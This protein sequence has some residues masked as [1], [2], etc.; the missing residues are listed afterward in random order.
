MK[1]LKVNKLRGPNIWANYPV[2]EAWVDLEEMKDTSS[3]MIPGFN[4]RL[5][6]WLPTMV[7][8]RCSIGE[9]GGFF[10]R[11]RRG[12]YMAHIL[13]HVTLE[14]QSL[15]G[16]P[17][18]FGRARETNTDG[19]YKVAIAYKEEKLALACLDKAFELIQ[20]AIHDTPLDVNAVVSEL[21]EYAYDVCLGPSTRSI[22]DAAKA[23]NIPWRRLNEGSLVQLGYGVHQRRICTAETDST[24]A[25]AESIAQDKELTRTLLRSIGIPTPEGR[26]VESAEDAWE[27]AEDIGLPVVVKPQYG[28]H[29]RGVATN[30]QTR[31]QVVAAYEAARQEGRSIIVERHAPGDDYRMLVVGGKLVAAARREPAHVIGDGQSTVQKLIDKVNEDP[32]RSDGHSTSLSLIKIDPVALG[33]LMD[34]GM[35]PDTIPPVGKKVLIRRNANLSTGGTAA[36]VTDQV[37]PDVA[38]HAVEAA[39]IIGLDIAGVDMVVQDISQPLQGQRGVIV[40]VNAGPGL[41]MHIE[42]SSGSPRPVGESIIEM[43]YPGQTNGRIPVISITGVNGKTTTT[44]LT[45]HIVASTGKKVG[46]TCTDGIYVGGRRIDSGDCSGPQSARSV[47]MNPFVEAAVLETARGG[48]LR[49]GLGFDFCDVGIVTNIGEGDHLGLSDIETIEQLAKVKRCIIEAVHKNGF[50]VLKANDPL[51]AEMAEKC[52][53]RVIFFAIDEND[54][55]L[56]DH[57]L[58]GQRVVFVRNGMIVIAEGAEE[59]AL[60]TLDK[61]PLT[62][63]GRILFQVENV[64]ASVAACWGAGLSIAQIVIGLESFSAHMDKV[65]GRFNLLDVHGATVVADYGHNSSSLLAIIEALGQFPHGHRTVVYSAAG[66]RRDVDMIRQGEILADHFDRIILYEDQYLRGRKPGEISSIFKRGMDSGKRVKEVYDFIGWEKAVE[67]ALNLIQAGDLMLLQADTIDETVQ[68]L[69]RAMEHNQLGREIDLNSALETKPTAHSPSPDSV[70]AD[71][72]TNKA[73]SDKSAT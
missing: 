27:A 58:K 28:N 59:T 62:H 63:Q 55:V 30:L 25:I 8:H 66:D 47:L 16:T 17:V 42:P 35:T 14:L 67:H 1:I 70:P 9:R 73:T 13:E 60:T 40:E 19:I 29:G 6:G 65:P 15:S 12:T 22:V 4:E 20:A 32:R 5:M 61:I 51:T 68:Y 54:P 52:K 31:Q 33:V 10:V 3:E 23:K 34:Q 57:R 18:G 43:M 2:L 37:H 41:R 50:G 45:A 48:I 71:P 56:S 7:E 26:S 39:R 49:E 53:G 11:L 38:R 46:M 72:V 24:S 69:Q 44:R 21:K 64:L 36:D